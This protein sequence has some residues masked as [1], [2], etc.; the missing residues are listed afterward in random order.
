M[1]QLNKIKELAS[2]LSLYDFSTSITIANKDEFGQI[3][4]ALNA[5]Q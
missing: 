5:A 1:N 2:R 3:G 4:D